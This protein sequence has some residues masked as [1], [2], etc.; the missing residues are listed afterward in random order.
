MMSGH[1]M[2][3]PD[4][5]T[6]T[7]AYMHV[8]DDLTPEEGIILKRVSGLPINY[9][10]LAVVSN[11]WRAAMAVKYKLEDTVLKQYDLSW[12]G[13]STLFIVWVWGPAEVRDIARLQGVSRPTI[14]SNINML[15]RRGWCARRDNSTDRR[16]VTVELTETGTQLIETLFPAFNQGESDISKTLTPDEQKQIAVLLRKVI[17][18]I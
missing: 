1:D 8:S 12:S 9:P 5:N 15:E 3:C 7:I 6:G 11:I 13:F 18:G 10:A 4:I 17:A 16:L 2:P 14:S